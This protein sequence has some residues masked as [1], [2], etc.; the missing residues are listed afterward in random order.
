MS[1]RQ[2]VPWVLA[3][4]LIAASALLLLLSRRLRDLSADYHKLRL[5]STLPHAGT[6]VPTFRAA[7]LSG[8]SITVGEAPDSAARQVV[9]VFNTTCPYCRAIIPLWH[10]MTD[11]IGRLG[12]VQVLAISLHPVDTT[13]RYVA[14]HALRYPVLTFP[15][16]KLQRLFRAVAVPQTVVLDW[17]GTVLYAKTGSLDPASLDSVY[18][19]VTGHAKP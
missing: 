1:V 8:D 14:Q 3:I 7:T 6:V 18:A 17:T 9:F 10:R 15:Q 11:S 19:S 2:V 4:A 5:L 13:R 12:R 16:P